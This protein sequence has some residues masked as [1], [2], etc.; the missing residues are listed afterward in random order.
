MAHEIETNMDICLTR[1]KDAPAWHKIDTRLDVIDAAAL[2]AQGFAR[3][4]QLVK[5]GAIDPQT[6][7]AIASDEYQALVAPNLDRSA[8]K[9]VS[10]VGGRF[11]CH[12]NGYESLVSMLAPLLDAGLLSVVTAGTVRGY[13]R[14][15]L[16][17]EVTGVE[18]RARIMANDDIKTYL[19]F[20]DGLDGKTAMRQFK[21]SV[22]I[23]CANTLAE[24]HREAGKAG[25]RIKHTE[26]FQLRLDEWRDMILQE[27]AALDKEAGVFR[28]LAAR[29]IDSAQLDTYLRE[30]FGLEATD[31]P[32]NG[33]QYMQAQEAHALDSAR[34]TL[35]GAYN[36][37]QA[38]LQWYGKGGKQSQAR[39]DNMFFGQGAR[40]NQQYLNAATAML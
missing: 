15:Y 10:I 4:T 33:S 7:A 28:Q 6:G 25:L 11:A 5:A 23:V 31:K 13:Q 9:V 16:T 8:V 27:Q 19:N 40:L 39:M 24:A 12:D 29:Q 38:T 21:S 36:A 34:G 18:L 22:R 14:G 30:C 26:S 1:T 20:T 37:A 17:T 35:W 2:R 3:P 32:R